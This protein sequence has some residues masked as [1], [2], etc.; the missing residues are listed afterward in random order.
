LKQDTCLAIIFS[1]TSFLNQ[2]CHE[3]QLIQLSM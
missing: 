1:L 3:Q 2:K